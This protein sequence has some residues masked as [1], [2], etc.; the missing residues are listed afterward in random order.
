[1]SAPSA[2]RVSVPGEGAQRSSTQ[3]TACQEL[4]RWAEGVGPWGARGSALMSHAEARSVGNGN[5]WAAL[6]IPR[7]GYNPSLPSPLSRGGKFKPQLV[8]LGWRGELGR[9]AGGSG[10]CHR[11]PGQGGSDGD[12]AAGALDLRHLAVGG[13]P[14]GWFARL[15]LGGCSGFPVPGGGPMVGKGL[16]AGMGPVAAGGCGR[17]T[18]SPGDARTCT[19]SDCPLISQSAGWGGAGASSLLLREKQASEGP[20]FQHPN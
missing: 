19:S 20:S 7:S 11:P 14:W 6:F 9:E 3:G 1:M 16:W 12:S 5:F 15:P 10:R 13:S 17:D 8:S 2:A 18:G 4:G